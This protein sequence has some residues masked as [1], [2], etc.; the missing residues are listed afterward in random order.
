MQIDFS[1]YIGV[2]VSVALIASA[3]YFIEKT[4]S[5][6]EVE[7]RLIGLMTFCVVSL[8][9]VWIIDKIILL[10]NPILTENEGTIVFAFIKD[11]TLMIFS[12]YFGRKG[13]NSQQ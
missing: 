6:K 13:K 9:S 10:R 2:A 1:T 5:N 11:T 7:D 4:S 3:I 8:V 12:Y